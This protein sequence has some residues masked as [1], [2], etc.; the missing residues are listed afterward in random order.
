[1]HHAPEAGPQELRSSHF[2]YAPSYNVRN[3]L[4]HMMKIIRGRDT[5]GHLAR[6]HGIDP[7]HARNFISDWIE[8]V[9][10]DMSS[11]AAADERQYR[12]F[13]DDGLFEDLM[14][15]LYRPREPMGAQLELVV[16]RMYIRKSYCRKGYGGR[17]LG[18]LEVRA[19]E[20]NARFIVESANSDMGAILARRQ[21]YFPYDFRLRAICAAYD[22]RNCHWLFAPSLKTN[23]TSATV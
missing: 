14:L 16:A 12:L 9:R 18:N 15:R 8:W 22:S 17:L 7:E 11:S 19:D 1:M 2:P 5:R 10:L 21:N 3:H 4:H 13:Y 6:K 20:I 23:T